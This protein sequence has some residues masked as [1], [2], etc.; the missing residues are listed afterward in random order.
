[1]ATWIFVCPGCKNAVWL[2]DTA[3]FPKI[4]KVYQELKNY[5]Q[6]H[7]DSY[8][9]CTCEEGK[10]LREQNDK[11]TLELDYVFDFGK[12]KPYKKTLKEVIE[13]DVTYITDF[14]LP[15]TDWD[16]SQEAEFYLK[17]HRN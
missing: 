5:T 3:G 13:T 11:K 17:D 4:P 12:Y 2:T 9:M 16:I 8:E 14:L 7:D 6:P 15:K 10:K 1:M